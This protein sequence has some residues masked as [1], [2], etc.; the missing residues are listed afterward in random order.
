MLLKYCTLY[1]NKFGKLSSLSYELE[2]Y[3]QPRQHI[4]EQRHHFAN[5]GPYS[6]SFVF[7]RSHVWMWELDHKWG[8]EELMLLN[9]GVGED[10]WESPL[11]SKEIKPVNP[12]RNQSLIFTGR[13]DAKA[14]APILWPPGMKSQLIRKDPNA[15]KDWGQEKQAKEDEMSGCHHWLNKHEYERTPEIWKDRETSMLQ[16]MGLQRVGHS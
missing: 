6:Q 14:E 13:T 11:D 16:S 3:D 7:S 2:S 4:K 15:G 8:V 1:A 12:N 10:S 5:T 9:C